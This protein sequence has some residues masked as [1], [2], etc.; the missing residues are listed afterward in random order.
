[1]TEQ[2]RRRAMTEVEKVARALKAQMEEQM[3]DITPS[4]IQREKGLVWLEGWFDL[5]AALDAARGESADE[6]S[7]VGR[8]CNPGDMPNRKWLLRFHDQDC[9]TGFWDADDLGE[10]EAE[11]QAREAWDCY[12]VAFNCHLFV[13]A[14]RVPTETAD[15]RQAAIV[16]ALRDDAQRCD[17]F[18]RSE[19]ECACGAWDTEPGERSYKRKGVEDIADWIESGE[20]RR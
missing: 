10:A 2:E 9:R 18:A 8:Y 11:R 12:A 20:W 3:D 5:K 13:S 1:M 14:E 19:G 17:C 15:E 6:P 16:A 4:S 7:G